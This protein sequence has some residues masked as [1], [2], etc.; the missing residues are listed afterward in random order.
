MYF[1]SGD[2]S[3]TQTPSNDPFAIAVG[4]TTLGIGRHDNRLFETGWSTGTSVLQGSKWVFKGEQGAG[5]GGPSVAGHPEGVR[6]HDWCR[7]T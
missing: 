3:G 5:G 6:Q 7:D 1:S 4:G 2:S